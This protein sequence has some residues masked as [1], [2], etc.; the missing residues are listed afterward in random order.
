MLVS[1]SFFELFN[2]SSVISS[3]FHSWLMAD[4]SSSLSRYCGNRYADIYSDQFVLS[5]AD[6]VVFNNINWFELPSLLSAIIVSN[7]DILYILSADS[8]VACA[9][10]FSVR[11]SPAIAGTR[12][13]FN[14][15]VCAVSVIFT[16]LDIINAV[17]WNLSNFTANPRFSL[18][19]FKDTL[20]SKSVVSIS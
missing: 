12:F 3:F 14:R 4:S 10:I 7:D 1:S 18:S 11:Q 16:G 9:V 8:I 13:N 2:T 20:S 15:T 19:S 5:D 17:R 6:T